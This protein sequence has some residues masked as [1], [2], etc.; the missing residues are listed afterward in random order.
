MGFKV[1]IRRTFPISQERVW[2]MVA[3]EEILKYP[4]HPGLKYVT[5][6]GDGEIRLDKPLIASI[7][8]IE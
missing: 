3:S 2:E 7:L 6:D 8:K 4:L 1:G 5:D